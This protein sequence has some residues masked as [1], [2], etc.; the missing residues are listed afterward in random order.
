MIQ[1]DRKPNV[2]LKKY[3]RSLDIREAPLSFE[4]AIASREIELPHQDPADRFIAATAIVCDLTLA[5]ADRFLLA[6]KRLSCLR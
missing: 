2:W 4:I 3:L 5:T 6:C 1:L